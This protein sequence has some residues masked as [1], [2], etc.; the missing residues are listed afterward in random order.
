MHDENLSPKACNAM[1]A[2]EE[3]RTTISISVGYDLNTQLLF[4]D[5]VVHLLDDVLRVEHCSS[6]VTNRRHEIRLKKGG[7]IVI[8]LEEP[9]IL[10]VSASLVETVSRLC[11]TAAGKA[12]AGET[13]IAVW[14]HILLTPPASDMSMLH[15]MRIMGQHR[16]HVGNMRCGD[17]ALLEFQYEGEPNPFFSRQIVHLIFRTCGPRHGLLSRKVA[18]GMLRLMRGLI[19]LAASTPFGAMGELFP[20]KPEH[21]ER[22]RGFASDARVV[23]LQMDGVSLWEASMR[24]LAVCGRETFDRLLGAL[25]AYEQAMLQKA[26]G[27]AII[28]FVTAIEA[29]CVPPVAWRNEGVTA[30]F[31][32]LLCNLCPGILEEVMKHGNFKEAFGDPGTIKKLAERIYKLRSEPVH[33]GRLGEITSGVFAEDHTASVRV[34]LVAAVARVA[35][36]QFMLTP[37]TPIAGHPNLRMRVDVPLQKEQYIALLQMAGKKTVNDWVRR[38]LVRAIRLRSAK[39]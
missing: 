12:A 27:A 3:P 26:E 7:Q 33:T 5:W 23:P 35:I 15:M 16:A 10:E 20:A 6:E 14:W 21:L 38:H 39:K 30:R 25:S 19:A 37:L 1:P 9:A 4:V 8:V 36:R 17:L 11:Q 29:L 13:G 34:A 32:D 28:F 24:L 18:S 31:S 2:D 22:S